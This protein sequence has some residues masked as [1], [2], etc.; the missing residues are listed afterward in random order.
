MDAPNLHRSDPRPSPRALRARIG[1][2]LLLLCCGSLA[3][4]EA[5]PFDLHA[6]VQPKTIPPAGGGFELQAK[7]TPST[8]VLEGGGYSV[9][10]VAAPAASC[11]SDTIFA[12]GFD[13]AI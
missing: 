8:R 11:S 3:D 1:A 12:N 4:A 10:A 5:S 7:L 2:A 9:A 6:S 13:P